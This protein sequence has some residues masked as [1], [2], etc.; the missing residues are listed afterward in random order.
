MKEKISV[1][2]LKLSA[3]LVSIW[4]RSRNTPS[5]AMSLLC[6]MLSAMQ[7]NIAFLTSSEDDA[8]AMCCIDAEDQATVEALLNHDSE[9]KAV[10]QFGQRVGLL[11]L[12]PHKAS[13]K[14]LGAVLQALTENG[15]AVHGVASSIAALTFV[16]DYD[17]LDDAVAILNG[18]MI[19]PSNPA[20]FRA[21][22][23]VRQE[24]LLK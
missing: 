5:A 16:V 21:D 9:L 7:V 2:G 24:A 17:C 15:L 23:K 12:Y 1:N 10:V 20:A 6:R 8:T 19:L 4:V 3:A 18:C 13:L 22:F 14:L 11:S